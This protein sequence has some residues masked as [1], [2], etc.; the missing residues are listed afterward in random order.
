MLKISVGMPVYNGEQYIEEAVLSILNQT[1]GR[2]ELIISDMR[3]RGVGALGFYV[4]AKARP[5]GQYG[6]AV[7]I[8]NA[9]GGDRTLVIHGTDDVVVDRG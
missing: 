8:S 9:L 5:L 1:E 2:F 3:E 7:L 6:T 4:H